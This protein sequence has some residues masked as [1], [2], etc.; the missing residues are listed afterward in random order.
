MPKERATQTAFTHKEYTKSKANM[1]RFCGQLKER[2]FFTKVYIHSAIDE[3]QSDVA[4]VSEDTGIEDPKTPERKRDERRGSNSIPNSDS[5]GEGCVDSE[6]NNDTENGDSE[7]HDG[8]GD[9][10]DESSSED[11]RRVSDSDTSVSKQIRSP[12]KRMQTRQTTTRYKRKTKTARSDCGDRKGEVAGASPAKKRRTRPDAATEERRKHLLV[13]F[14][15]VI[16]STKRE[17]CISLFSILNFL[18][19]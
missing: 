5:D 17:Y 11:T 10:H 7:Y 9:V 14:T 1:Q 8:D 15:K 18:T 3:S 4:S 13:P 16:L 12:A 6:L 19:W 2:R